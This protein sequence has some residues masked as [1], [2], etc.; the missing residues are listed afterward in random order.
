MPDAGENKTVL[1]NV[2]FI[3]PNSTD[4][5]I[6]VE[7]I[8]ITEIDHH[9]FDFSNFNNAV[10]IRVYEKIDGNIYKSLSSSLY[11]TDYTNPSTG[12]TPEIVIIVLNGGGQDMKITLQSSISEG[13][14]TTIKG[15]VR[16]ELRQ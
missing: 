6:L 15:T 4:E 8:K 10:T 13:S 2:E 7:H 3:H 12:L 14:G 9:H 1:R 11:P 5:E 16:D